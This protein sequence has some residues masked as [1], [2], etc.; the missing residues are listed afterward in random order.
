MDKF[1]EYYI[2][3]NKSSSK[4]TKSTLISAISRLQ[5][6][7]KMNFDEWNEK[8]FNNVEGITDLLI[9]EY[10]L[11]TVILSIL[12]IIRFL[13]YKKSN[14]TTIQEYKDVLNELIQEKRKDEISQKQTIDEAQNWISYPELKKQVE[15]LAP[16]Y[17][18][19][20]KAFTKMRNFVILSL[21]TL[22]PPTRIGNYLEMKL[23]ETN[24]R[25]VKSL[26]KKY[27]Y[28]TKQN[29]KYKMIFNNYK[30]SKYIGKVEHTI[31]NEILNKILDKYINEYLKG[32]E[33]FENAN[34]K[35]MT[36]SNFTQAQESV[37]T[38]LL[39]KKLSTNDFRHIFLSWFLSTNP[40][41][42][43]KEKIAHVIGQK[44]K[45]SRME[46]YQRRNEKGDLVV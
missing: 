36:Q 1:V 5:K 16:E 19:N 35:P 45:P 40:T 32:D 34:G 8:T 44:Y 10:S 22:Q 41:I 7:I 43:E 18:T 27:N 20:K 31:E 3:K 12:M 46:L 33:L 2:N 14:L 25:D 42:E 6:V 21:F 13:E 29:D 17:L 37:S 28:I 30:T 39:G 26:N 4:S 38:E 15:E 9:E 23:K 24:K 11:N